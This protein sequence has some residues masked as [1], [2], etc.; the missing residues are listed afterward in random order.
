M[1]CFDAVHG[2]VQANVH[3][4]YIGARSRFDG[5]F[6]GAGDGGDAMPERFQALRDI[7]SN[8]A[9]IFDQQNAI[10]AGVLRRRGRRPRGALGCLHI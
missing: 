4:H 1:G 6:A 8:E 9:F 10:R 7:A 2:P 5:L 3:E